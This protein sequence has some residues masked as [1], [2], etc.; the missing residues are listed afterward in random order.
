MKIVSLDIVNHK[1]IYTACFFL[2]FGIN[3][4]TSGQTSPDTPILSYSSDL[5]QLELDIWNDPAFKKRFTESYIAETD[6]EPRVTVDEREK[7]LKVLKLI[8]SDK[9]DEAAKMLEKSRNEAATAVFDFTLANIY[10]QQDK[11]DEAATV[12]QIAVDKYPKFRRAWRNLGLIYIRQNDFEKALPA[13]TRVIELGGGDVIT[14]GLLGFAYSSVENDL[15]AESA[16]RMAI[17]LDPI[18]IDWKMGLAR[19]FFKQERFAEAIALCRQLIKNQPD[20]AELWLLQANAYIGFNQPLKAAENFELIDRLGKSTV[21]SLNMIGDIYINEE[22]YEM[23]VKSYIRAMEK[24]PNDSPQRA[25][26][27]AKVLA[28]RSAFQETRRLIESIETLCG[29]QLETENRKDLLKLRA[30]LAVADGSGD[31]EEVDV[32]KEIVELD[33]LDGDALILLGQY[34]GRTGDTEKAIFYYE[35]AESI[36]KYEADAKVRH[37]QLLVKNGKYTEALPLLKRAQQIKPRDN[38]Q[39]YLNQVERVTKTK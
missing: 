25:I 13:L 11:L 26:R 12:Y 21:D 24:D 20:R 27:A 6:I 14:Y 3:V 16:Y 15:S 8:S 38:I 33:P 39:E 37:A 36:E 32:L 10:F 23:A 4:C 30:R 9:M 17:L 5:S 18:T 35:R 19:S 29:N 34:Y 2:I 28:A 1:F 7:M 31:Q 22:L